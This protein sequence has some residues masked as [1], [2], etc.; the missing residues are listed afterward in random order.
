MY[1][2]LKKQFEDLIQLTDAEFEYISSH[3]QVKRFKKHA[4]I[5]HPGEI[6]NYEYFVLMVQM[7]SVKTCR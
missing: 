4:I 5:L 7:K 6:V 2:A 3:Y 1:P